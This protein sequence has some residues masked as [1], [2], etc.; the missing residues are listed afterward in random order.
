MPIRLTACFALT[1]TLAGI[2]AVPSGR[3]PLQETGP[4][5]VAHGVFVFP[6]FNATENLVDGNATI[7]IGSRAVLIVDAPSPRLTREQLAWKTVH[8]VQPKKNLEKTL[9]LNER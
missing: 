4:E 7:I 2:G 6:S 8:K 9:R 3:E 1:L 5:E